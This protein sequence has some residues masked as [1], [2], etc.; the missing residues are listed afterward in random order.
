MIDSIIDAIFDAI[1][2]K[3]E[4]FTS[5]LSVLFFRFVDSSKGIFSQLGT[6]ALDIFTFKLDQNFF[7][8]IIG[9][10]FG[11]FILKFVFGKAID[12]ISR[13]LDFT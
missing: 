2:D 13:F 3:L 6:A 10:I 1:S 7:I 8:T 9:F 12:L 4:I 5:F 11:F